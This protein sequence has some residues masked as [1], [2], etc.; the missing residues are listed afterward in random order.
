MH[1]PQPH[2]LDYDWRYSDEAVRTICEMLPTSKSVVAGGAPSIVRHLDAAGRDAILVDRQ[3]FQGVK[4]HLI[5]EVGQPRLKI[6]G[7]VAVLDPPWYPNDAIQWISWAAGIVGTGG[8]IIVTLWPADTRPGAEAERALL[9]EWIGD[10]A[11]FE[12]GATVTYEAPQF[13][14][15]A[16]A[17]PSASD[18]LKKPRIGDLVSIVVGSEP[19]ESTGPEKAERWVRFTINDY[20]LGIRTAPITATGRF[21]EP[22][23]DGGGWRWPHVSRRAPRRGD[24]ALWSSQNEVAKVGD[25]AHLL[26]ILRSYVRGDISPTKLFDIYPDLAHWA[27]PKPPFWRVAEWNHRQ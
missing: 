6:E 13:E 7:A 23:T 24:I 9:S 3:P 11:E 17:L 25:G 16:C 5:A 18:A 4:K 26:E 10:W 22:L 21:L 19:P 1:L 20:Q 14:Q 2:P 27:I 8:Q 12:T 15:A